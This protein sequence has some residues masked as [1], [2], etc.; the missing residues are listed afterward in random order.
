VKNDKIAKN[1]NAI[2]AKEKISTD[3]ES[4]AFWKLLM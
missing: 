3:L 1:V 4:I 2:K